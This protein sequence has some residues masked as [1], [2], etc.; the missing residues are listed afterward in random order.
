[1]LIGEGPGET[2]NLMG[3]PFRG[4]S[5]ALLT[6][7]LMR[8]GINRDDVY[9]T[10]LVKYHVPGNE[11][12]TPEDIERDHDELQMEI[13]A[14]EPEYIGL[15][16]RV[17]SRQFLGNIDLEW[18][19]GLQW[20]RNRTAD[21]MPMYHPALGLHSPDALPLIQDD[22]RQFALMI[23]GKLEVVSHEDRHPK[24]RYVLLK[25]QLPLLDPKLPIYIDTEGSVARPWGLSFTQRDGRA[26]VILAANTKI[27][28]QLGSFIALNEMTVVL[29]NAMHDIP[30]LRVMGIVFDNFRDTMIRAYHLCI[31]PQGLKPL[32][33]R[34]AS[35][36]MDSYDDVI[37]AARRKK[38]ETYLKGVLAW[39]D[40]HWV[41]ESA[42]FSRAK[43]KKA[44]KAKPTTP[45]A[46]K[47]S[48]KISRRRPRSSLTL[49]GT[50]QKQL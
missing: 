24:P 10:N 4:K 40:K 5:G 15:L 2:E 43:A 7:M 50:Y 3:A 38:C 34:H 21:L 14:V 31:E 44:K 23:K 25:N 33:R 1:M 47:R 22:I 45:R 9:V 13:A 41:E 35:M 39:L 48:A 46:G 17:V 37:S 30:V 20:H 11:D 49:A 18:A 26:Y 19:H 32:A 42:T 6:D 28:F 12:P 8:Q 29:H 27:L 36:V 16:G